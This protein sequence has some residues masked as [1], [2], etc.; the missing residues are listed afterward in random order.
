M[1][2]AR[3][4]LLVGLVG[5][6]ILA[7]CTHRPAVPFIKLAPAGLGRE[8]AA[9]QRLQ[10]RHGDQRPEL[11]ALLEVDGEEVRLAA[12]ML[13][14]T[15]ERLRWD[16]TY[17]QEVRAP[18]LPEQITGER[19]LSDLQ[20]I[21]WPV[22]AVRAGLPALCHLDTAPAQRTLVC[23]QAVVVRVDYEGEPPGMQRATL[24]NRVYDY[25]LIVE[26]GVENAA[27]NAP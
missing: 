6:L 3:A 24:Y 16:G 10:F 11:Q 9:T 5:L 17:L 23:E 4:G 13:G 12:L 8:F 7:A 18:W 19:I 27:E 25:E 1:K 20:L 22:A 2:L 15:V 26:N 14:E 21:L